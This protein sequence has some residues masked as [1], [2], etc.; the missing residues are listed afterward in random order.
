MSNAPESNVYGPQKD[1]QEG[2]F[3]SVQAYLRS[4]RGYC[5]A[6]FSLGN[7]DVAPNAQPH[8]SAQTTAVRAVVADCS[9]L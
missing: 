3:G 4:H 2:C 8:S 1:V 5:F 7:F 6:F 9:A